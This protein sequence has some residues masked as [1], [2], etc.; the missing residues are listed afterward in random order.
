MALALEKQQ[1]TQEQ[2]VQGQ[3]NQTCHENEHEHERVTDCDT[4]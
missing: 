2:K 1:V 3:E 4:Q